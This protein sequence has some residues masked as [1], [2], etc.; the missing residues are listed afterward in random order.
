MFRR[1]LKLLFKDYPRDDYKNIGTYVKEAPELPLLAKISIPWAELKKVEPEENKSRSFSRVESLKKCL[2]RPQS[3][4]KFLF[5]VV[6][7]GLNET[8][9]NDE[10]KENDLEDDKYLISLPALKLKN[11]ISIDRDEIDGITDLYV[12]I[13]KYLQDD[14]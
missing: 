8:L 11:L 7:N 13:R 9:K 1:D 14:S 3:F 4:E 6:K 5:D 2:A 12:L 10:Y